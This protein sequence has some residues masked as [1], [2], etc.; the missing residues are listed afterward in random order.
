M[1]CIKGSYEKHG[2]KST[3]EEQLPKIKE[4]WK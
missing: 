2:D 3:L 4:V 1:S